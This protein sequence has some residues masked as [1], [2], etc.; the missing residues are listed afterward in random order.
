M[1]TSRHATRT[2]IVLTF[3]VA[4]ASAAWP[5]ESP[6]AGDSS[7][8]E[9][10]A[11]MAWGEASAESITRAYLERIEAFDGAVN[12]VIAVN[13]DAIDQARALDEEYRRGE[14]RGPLHGIPVLLKDNIES[15]DPM[16][17]TAGSLALSDNVTGRD[18]FFVA[19]LREAGVVI[20]GKTN[21]SEWANFRSERSS[22]GW[23][24]IGGQTNNPHDLTRNPCGSS[25]G[26]A[27]AAAMGFAA[28]TVGTETNGSIVCPATANGVVGF[29]PTVGLVSRSGIVPISHSQDTA[30]PL[31][32]SVAD[33]AVLLQAMIGRDEDDPA[34]EISGEAT[35]WRLVEHLRRDGLAGKRIGIVRSQSGFHGEVDALL[36]QATADLEAAGAAVVDGLEFEGAEGLGRAAYDVLL[37]EFK[38]DL[39]A[40][41]ADLPTVEDLPATTLEELIAFNEA[42]GDREM[43]WFGQEVFLES[44]A[45]GPL[46]EDTY[47]EALKK[48][49]GISRRGIDSLLEEHDLDALI[50]PTGGPAW[51]TDLVNGDHFIG[52]SSSYPARAGYPIITVPMGFVH[53]LPVGLS[54]FGTALSEPTLVEIAYAYE[55]ATGHRKVPALTR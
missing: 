28:V 33:A 16:P 6:R 34:T 32:R 25:S 21:L 45:K 1:R 24:G 50:A 3:A 11:M 37:Y 39:N 15:R 5:A 7:I 30:G 54:F 13:P 53:G 17:T 20:L 14:V 41:L 47:L 55:S 26:S 38:H 19:L 35:G 22:S 44:Q 36:E 4:A 51:K 43:P 2:L 31:A 42:N 8:A 29:K 48:V 9:L 18:A 12:A 10:Q 46:T 23:S 49:R 27:A 40:Y 52:S